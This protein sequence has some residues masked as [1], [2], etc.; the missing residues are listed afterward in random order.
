M[1]LT[2]PSLTLV[3]V[4]ILLDRIARTAYVDADRVALSVGLSVGLS[5]I[6]VSLA[7]TAE[8]I[9][10]PFGL[11]IRVSPRNHVLDR[12]PDPVR[13]DNFSPEM[14]VFWLDYRSYPYKGSSLIATP[15]PHPSRSYDV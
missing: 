10:V 2:A 8:P 12:G 5:A 11:K 3:T 1:Y 15:K 14:E 7:K 4:F 9:E 13:R 6:V